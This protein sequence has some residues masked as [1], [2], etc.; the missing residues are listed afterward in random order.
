MAFNSFFLAFKWAFLTENLFVEAIIAYYFQFFGYIC[1]YA[2]L[3]RHFIGH[4][5]YSVTFFFVFYSVCIHSIIT[6]NDECMNNFGELKWSNIQLET[7]SLLKYD[8][9]SF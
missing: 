8:T 9:D 5:F 4:S 1:E 2:V 6:E 7:N 3:T